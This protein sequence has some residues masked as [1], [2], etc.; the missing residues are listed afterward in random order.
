METFAVVTAALVAG[1][2]ATRRERFENPRPRK[3]MRSGGAVAVL[4]GICLLM[5]SGCTVSPSVVAV[6]PD[7]LAFGHAYGD[8]LA[9][10]GAK[11]AGEYCVECHPV[12]AT[13][14]TRGGAPPLDLLL[15]RRTSDRLTDD[16]IAGLKADH[17]GMPIFDFN[18]TA[19]LSLVAYL[20]S[21][22]DDASGKPL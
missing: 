6:G 10:A 3:R 15:S 1:R 5:L 4:A 12:R 22:K 8:D 16:L 18:V 13:G 9:A 21:L 19:A 2:L 11:L 17:G 20:E 7:P 14:K